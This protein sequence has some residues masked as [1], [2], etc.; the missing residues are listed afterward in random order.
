MTVAI[1]DLKVIKGEYTEA[2]QGF[3]KI[4]VDLNMRRWWQIYLA[5][6]QKRK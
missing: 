6:F 2:P 3:Q 4:P 1:T 5:L